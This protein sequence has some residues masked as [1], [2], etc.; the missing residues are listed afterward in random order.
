MKSIPIFLIVSVITLMVSAQTEAS[1][2]DSTKV[3]SEQ[4]L[5]RK[6]FDKSKLYYG[7]GLSLSFGSYTVIGVRPM[8][9]YK[10]TPKLST[11]VEITYE[12]SS[13]ESSSSSSYG[14][15][16]FARYRLV[17]Q[18]YFHVEY[19]GMNYE[20]Y[21]NFE[22]EREWVPFLWLG[23]GYSKPVAKN[24]W[25]NAQVLFDVLQD[26]NSPYSSWEPYFSVGIGVGF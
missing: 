25:L 26:E 11:G 18:L 2:V 14:G 5:Q 8:V 7:G 10:L 12:Y 13:Y 4:E 6:G 19:S 9:G 16:L 3:Q 24:V 20:L 23:G 15:S 1:V 17:P 22:E 21:Y